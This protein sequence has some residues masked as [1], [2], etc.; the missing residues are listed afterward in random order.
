MIPQFECIAIL[1]TALDHAGQGR[2]FIL[3]NR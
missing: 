3:S 2:S 1:A